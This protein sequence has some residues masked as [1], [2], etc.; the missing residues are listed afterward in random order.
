[1]EYY[2]LGTL[3][4]VLISLIIKKVF[5]FEKHKAL[6]MFICI[7]PL[8][9]ISAL[10]YDV[11]WDYLTGYKEG[12]YVVGR[13]NNSYFSEAGFNL[14]IKILF[15]ITDNYII[16]FIVMSFLTALFFS[17]CYKVYG[18]EKYTWL[19]I[20]L[21]VLTRYYFCSLNIVRQALA[22]MIVLYALHYLPKKQYLRYILF[23]ILALEFHRLSLIYIP[24]LFILNCNFKK[25]NDILKI[26]IF[27]PIIAIVLYLYISNSK[28]MNYFET[29]FGNDG[30]LVYSEL[31][32]C[33]AI[34]FSVL[35]VYKKL[36]KK[37]EMFQIF[38]NMQLLILI[39]S[40][41]SFMLPTI[42]R[43]I[44]YL[45]IQNIFFIPMILD[46]IEI[47]TNKII[48]VLLLFSFL[49]I[50]FF[51]QTIN[52]DSYSILPYKTILNI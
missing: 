8:T 46:K 23:I 28:Y 38:F 1:M 17:L 11:G 35:I 51:N 34:L 39:F 20:V 40:L 25:K 50:V 49:G 29:M 19:Y 15:H 2:I 52:A 6:K 3:L 33:I 45:S 5:G 7:L 37:D 30:S 26:I 32:I 48:I 9:L 44:W 27:A 10:R 36:E 16:L 14:L 22:M 41:L 47:K 12:F 13:Y 24:L 18:M 43:I 31:F 42:D 4:S 21:Y